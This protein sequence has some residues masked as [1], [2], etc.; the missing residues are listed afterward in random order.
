[1]AD[2]TDLM[3]AHATLIGSIVIAY[4]EVQYLVF[5]LFVAFSG[6]PF[7]QARSVFFALKSDRSQRDITL[8]AGETA[9]ADHPALWDRFKRSVNQINEL[10]GERNAAVHTMW[11]IDWQYWGGPSLY[12]ADKIG[13]AP[14]AIPP[15]KLKDDF[16][17]QCAEL[18]RKLQEHI[19]ELE[20]I[21]SEY[22][23]LTA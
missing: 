6:M 17:A 4:N 23:K 13:P 10:A 20:R 16:P 2:P 15:K 1:M 5:V 22:E 18:S 9:L 12:F 11:A 14:G 19:V 3:K 8:A 7:E 21:R